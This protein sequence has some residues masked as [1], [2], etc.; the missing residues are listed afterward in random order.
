MGVEEHS[1]MMAQP[2]KQRSH[3]QYAPA[4]HQQNNRQ[5]PRQGP[6]GQGKSMLWK[7]RVCKRWWRASVGREAEEVE[8]E[9]DTLKLE[10]LGQVQ[11]ANT[12]E[13]SLSSTLTAWQ[14]TEGRTS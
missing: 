13:R 4:H 11:K 8:R 1:T 6:S 10:V 2:C 9:R 7:S 5:H 14:Y 3:L 12:T